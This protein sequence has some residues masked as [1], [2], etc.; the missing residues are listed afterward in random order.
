MLER[1]GTRLDLGGI[2]K[3]YA[4]DRLLAEL[5]ALGIDRALVDAGGDIAAGRPPEGLAGWKIGIPAGDGASASVQ[6][7]GAAVATSGDR[8][9][10]IDFDG[11]RYSHIV[12]PFTGRGST[13]SHSVTVIS[14]NATL[15]DA[16]A[17]AFSVLPP[18]DSIDLADRLPDVEAR[19]IPYGPAGETNAPL[20]TSGFSLVETGAS[21]AVTDS[22]H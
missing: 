18:D 12:N 14:R 5:S 1:P 19:I 4:A 22:T 6:V 11:R 3:G 13:E 21:H 2:A 17:S 20:R 10:F 16:L 7:A 9:R 15:A 8:Y